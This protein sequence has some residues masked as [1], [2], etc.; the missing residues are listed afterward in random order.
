MY[1]IPSIPISYDIVSRYTREDYAIVSKTGKITRCPR[2]PPL[3]ANAPEKE[4]AGC[5]GDSQKQLQSAVQEKRMLKIKVRGKFDRVGWQD[6]QENVIP[7]PQPGMP[8]VVP[9]RWTIK[10]LGLFKVTIV[11]EVV[12]GQA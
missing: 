9:V 10:V 11:A 4:L 3:S 6:I 12:V 8:T 5:I 2:Y 1:V 7:L